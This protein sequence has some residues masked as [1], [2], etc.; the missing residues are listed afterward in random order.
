MRLYKRKHLTQCGLNLRRRADQ[1][2]P[3][4]LNKR[5][6]SLEDINY[7]GPRKSERQGFV[8]GQREPG[9]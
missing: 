6:N 9:I 1:K 4:N 5:K 3:S 7:G 2:E 8:Q